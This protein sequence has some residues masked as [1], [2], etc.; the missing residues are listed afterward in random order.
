M[1]VRGKN[2]VVTCTCA[3][4]VVARCIYS[5]CF[6]GKY[7]VVCFSTAK[8]TKTLPPEKYPLY[9]ILIIGTSSLAQ[10]RSQ[11]TNVRV[12][13]IRTICLLYICILSMHDRGSKHMIG[14]AGRVRTGH[15]SI[16][17][18]IVYLCWQRTI[19]NAFCTRLYGTI[20][21]I[22]HESKRYG[23]QPALACS[24]YLLRN[25]LD[26]ATPLRSVLSVVSAC[27]N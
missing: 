7:F 4:M 14:R 21:C 9:G 26:R 8:T 11:E 18:R 27:G 1:R 23:T 16:D 19:A 22:Y 13:R 10:M 24:I 12:Q 25:R 2:F 17:K 6:V 3:L 5:N 15:G 20:V